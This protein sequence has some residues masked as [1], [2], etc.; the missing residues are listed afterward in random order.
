M[1]AMSEGQV[2]GV[3]ESV[4]ESV[5]VAAPDWTLGVP[6]LELPRHVSFFF[7]FFSRVFLSFR[8]K[9]VYIGSLLFKLKYFVKS[10]VVNLIIIM[11]S[12]VEEDGS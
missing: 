7:S 3:L 11:W 8:A 5:G 9:C 6:Q 10:Q 1:R 4:R 12:L 2:S